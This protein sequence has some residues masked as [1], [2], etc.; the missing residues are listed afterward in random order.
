MDKTQGSVHHTKCFLRSDS[1]SHS[2]LSELQE[3]NPP[4]GKQPRNGGTTVTTRTQPSV[5]RP[6]WRLRT[7]L[8]TTFYLHPVR[9]PIS[10]HQVTRQPS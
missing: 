2:C 9:L 4:S 3:P 5:S 7:Q 10:V 8:P 1:K 6:E